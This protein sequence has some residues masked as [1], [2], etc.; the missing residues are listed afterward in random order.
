MKF[1]DL[2]NIRSYFFESKLSSIYEPAGVIYT[3]Q[4]FG[5]E[6]N[7][8]KWHIANGERPCTKLKDCQ[9]IYSYN[10]RNNKKISSSDEEQLIEQLRVQ[11]QQREKQQRW[12]DD[13]GPIDGGLD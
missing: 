4:Y 1:K 11:K 7:C 9:E 10:N 12:E 6:G 3:A 13:V 5:I 8:K 2:I